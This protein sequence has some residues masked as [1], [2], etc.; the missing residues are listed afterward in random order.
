MGLFIIYYI[1]CGFIPPNPPIPD[2]P[3]PAAIPPGKPPNPPSPPNAPRL[4]SPPP[5][6]APAPA[7]T[8]APTPPAPKFALDSVE[9]PVDAPELAADLPLTRCTVTPSSILYSEMG[10][11]S[12]KI[13]PLKMSLYSSAGTPA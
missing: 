6:P 12:F 7:P 8:P 9:A 5:K 10:F 4:G 11:S 1:I 3:P 2:G 13:L